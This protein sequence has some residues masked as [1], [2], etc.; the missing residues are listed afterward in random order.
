[1]SVIYAIAAILHI[2]SILGFGRTPFAEA[3]LSWQLSDIAY[4]I[5]DTIAAIGLWQQSLM[6][7]TLVPEWFVV[8]AEQLTML[9]G[10]VAYH[11]I[12]IAIY[13][14]LRHFETR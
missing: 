9:R 1:M 14:G 2:G 12:A 7:F 11:L 13:F 6:L 10:F 8:E 5:I 3:P 4:G